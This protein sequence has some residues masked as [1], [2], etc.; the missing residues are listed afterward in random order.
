MFF[1]LNISGRMNCLLLIRTRA[2]KH[3]AKNVLSKYLN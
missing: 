3:F 1:V 2:G